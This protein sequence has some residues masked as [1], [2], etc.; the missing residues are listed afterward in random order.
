MRSFTA[1]SFSSGVSASAED[2]SPSPPPA[3]PRAAYKRRD[4]GAGSRGGAAG[5]A[6]DPDPV[7]TPPSDGSDPEPAMA[8]PALDESR[9]PPERGRNA[10][11]P[12]TTIRPPITIVRTILGRIESNAHGRGGPLPC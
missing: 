2:E 1:S 9:A 8:S 5:R 12:A 3:L 4:A 6:F 7:M 10:T 11:R